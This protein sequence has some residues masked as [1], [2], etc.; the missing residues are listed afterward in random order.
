MCQTTFSDLS[1]SYLIIATNEET[2]T[3]S[4]ENTCIGG[5]FSYSDTAGEIMMDDTKEVS[6]MYGE[7]Q[8]FKQTSQLDM[9]FGTYR[10]KF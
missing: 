4:A 8:C 6:C 7:T 5:A 10:S 1:T 2:A 9:N 3:G